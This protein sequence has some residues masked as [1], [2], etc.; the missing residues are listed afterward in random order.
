MNQTGSIKPL[1]TLLES[2]LDRIVKLKEHRLSVLEGLNSLDDILNQTTDGLD[3]TDELGDWFGEHSQWLTEKNLKPA[4]VDRIGS[5]LSDI[6][7]KIKTR[8]RMSPADDKISSE[9]DRWDDKM[10]KTAPKLTLVRKAENQFVQPEPEI[11][12]ISLF[13]SKL[14]KLTSLFMDYVGDKQHIMTI[15]DDLL[16]SAQIQKNKDA[17]ILSGFIIY[18][19]KQNGYKVGPYVK[20]LKEAETLIGKDTLRA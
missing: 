5:M 16:K 11:D 14:S 18:Y 8:N 17:L 6:K 19:L 7:N 20:K 9:I 15:L 1:E 10:Q 12:T 3:I 4:D 13:I 2:F